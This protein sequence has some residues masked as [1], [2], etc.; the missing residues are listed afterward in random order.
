LSIV[1]TVGKHHKKKEKKG[2]T[3]IN[4]NMWG[5][6]LGF[7][8]LFLFCCFVL[9]FWGGVGLWCLPTVSTIDNSSF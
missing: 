8:C 3:M 7:F 4:K 6:S 9:F 1:E 2:Q 5:G